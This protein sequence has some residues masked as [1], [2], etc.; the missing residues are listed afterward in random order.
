MFK[1]ISLAAVIVYFAVLIYIKFFAEP[2]SKKVL[3][4]IKEDVKP[5]N[6]EW[7]IFGFHRF[8]EKNYCKTQWW[9]HLERGNNYYEKRKIIRKHMGKFG[10]RVFERYYNPQDYINIFFAENGFNGENWEY[11]CQNRK[12]YQRKAE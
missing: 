4:V 11:R 7:I 1:L 12:V 2:K 8:F 6:V 9:I 10:Y 5:I 3:L